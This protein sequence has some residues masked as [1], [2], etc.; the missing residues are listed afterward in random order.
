MTKNIY[1]LRRRQTRNA[2]SISSS[3]WLYRRRSHFSRLDYERPSPKNSWCYLPSLQT[4]IANC[5]KKNELLLSIGSTKK[6]PISPSHKH[7]S[8]TNRHRCLSKDATPTKT[9]PNKRY[10]PINQNPNANPNPT[11]C[12]IIFCGPIMV[13]LLYMDFMPHKGI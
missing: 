2:H 9:T 1:A 4:E 3:S 8:R 10:K 6:I 7:R 12:F 13:D 5:P 11:Y